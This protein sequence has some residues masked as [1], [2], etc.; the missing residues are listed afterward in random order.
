M[1]FFFFQKYFFKCVFSTLTFF[2]FFH[3]FFHL[4]FDPCLHSEFIAPDDQEAEQY[5][6]RDFSNSSNKDLFIKIKKNTLTDKM[7]KIN[8]EKTSKLKK[9]YIH[10]WGI[11]VT[12]DYQ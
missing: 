4:I 5:N 12:N 8:A 1:F 10:K 7:F 9:I 11:H 3:S 6:Y 2:F